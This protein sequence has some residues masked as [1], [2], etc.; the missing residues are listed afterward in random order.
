MRKLI[1]T[2]LIGILCLSGLAQGFDKTKLD[3]YFDALETNNKFMGS[4]AV[5]KDG[6]VIY[7]RS[8]GFSDIENQVKANENSIYRIGSISKTFTSVLV[9]KALEEKKLNLDQTI[10]TYFP[11]IKNAEKITIKHLLT[12]RSGIH[13]FTDDKD[14]LTWNTQP[15][16]EKEMVEI[17]TKAGSDFEPGTKAEYSNSN[18]VLLS[19][20]LEKTF[21]QSYAGL[22]QK[23]IVQPVGLKNTRFGGKIN[24]EKGECKSY[25]FL[26]NWNLEPETDM[27]IPTG[28]GGIVSTPVD[29]VKF[30][31]ALF[32]GKLVKPETLEMMKTMEDNFGM[33]LFKIPFYD[34]MAYGHTGGIDGFSS[35]FA[36][37]SDGNIS[38]ALTSNG[39]NFNNNNIS[40]AVLSA[41][42]GKTYDIPEFSTYH[43]TTEELDKYLGE[44]TS[45]EIPL[46]I[47]VT[48][49]SNT[50]IA[51]ATGQSAFPLEATEKDKFKFD[52]AGVVLEF[53]PAEKTMVLKQGG[54]QFLYTKE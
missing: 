21:H 40:I 52:Q 4:V 6:A 37:F 49:V 46:I 9:M 19:Y 3:H 18:F 44:Y 10:E 51:Q 53:N 14:Y 42:Y 13:N 32:G 38:Y 2:F 45:K 12:H 43:I 29:L 23:Y 47:S 26:G 31:D 16:T 54:G 48:K 8:V 39:T 50:L 41:V 7:S 35:V 34:R 33:G 22:L 36:C 15:R 20:I 24:P 17:I 27:S 28:A 30:S 11:T 25:S 5:S 1:T